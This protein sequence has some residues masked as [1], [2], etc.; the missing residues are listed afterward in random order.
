MIKK[1]SV[2]KEKKNIINNNSCF[3]FLFLTKYVMPFNVLVLRCRN[4]TRLR[5]NDRRRRT[6]HRNRIILKCDWA[7]NVFTLKS[8]LIKLD[9]FH[10]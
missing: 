9:S 7:F 8:L 3:T 6:K 5:I 4:L 10:Y 1:A 2:F